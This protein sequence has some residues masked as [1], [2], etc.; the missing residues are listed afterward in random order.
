ML[1]TRAAYLVFLVGLWETTNFVS[2]YYSTILGYY[3]TSY[4]I[5]M[6]NIFKILTSNN[7]ENL[8]FVLF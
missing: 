3:Y 6:Q 8:V 5:I 7:N 2:C 1:D 4:V